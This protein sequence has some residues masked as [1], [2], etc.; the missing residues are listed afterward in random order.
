[1]VTNIPI[2]LPKGFQCS[3]IVAGIK[4]SENKDLGLIFLVDLNSELGS[5]VNGQRVGELY[6]KDGDIIAFESIKYRF[7]AT[8]KI[9]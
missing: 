3:G 7:S 6:L 8:G 5:F 4:E 2:P 9:R 1:M